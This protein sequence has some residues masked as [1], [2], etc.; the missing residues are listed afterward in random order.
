MTHQAVVTVFCVM[1]LGVTMMV[2]ERLRPSHKFPNVTGWLARAIA[3]NAFQVAAVY[4]AGFVWNALMLGH[5][6]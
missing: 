3:I 2:V 4:L 5:R 1:C 6:P